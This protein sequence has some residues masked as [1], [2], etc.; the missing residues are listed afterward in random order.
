MEDV[1]TDSIDRFNYHLLQLIIQM[2]NFK[3]FVHRSDIWGIK[4]ANGSWRG[5]IGL[6]NRSEVDLMISGVRWDNERYG[7]FDQTTSTYFFKY[8]MD[9]CT[10]ESIKNL[11]SS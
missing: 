5:S 8:F 1:Q 4:M 7:A 11:I 3:M 10:K 6:L 2:F 9:F